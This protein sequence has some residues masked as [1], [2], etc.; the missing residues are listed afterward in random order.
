MTYLFVYYCALWFSEILKDTIKGTQGQANKN[1][2]TIESS[3]VGIFSLFYT[4]NLVN[5]FCDVILSLLIAL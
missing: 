5:F 2:I 1:S 4:R 3:Y